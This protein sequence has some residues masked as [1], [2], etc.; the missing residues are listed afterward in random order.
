MMSSSCRGE[1]FAEN[2]SDDAL[3]LASSP[4]NIDSDSVGNI[5]SVG[6]NVCVGAFLNEQVFASR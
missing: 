6:F 2:G 4:R 1:A 3:Q 5:D